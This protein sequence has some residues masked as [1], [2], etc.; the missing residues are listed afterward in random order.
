MYELKMVAVSLMQTPVGDGS[1][2]TAGPT[3]EYIE[4][5]QDAVA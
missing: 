3:F 4:V 2:F 5:A 1:A